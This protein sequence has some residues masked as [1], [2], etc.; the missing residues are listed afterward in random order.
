MGKEKNRIGGIEFARKNHK[1]AKKHSVSIIVLGT[2]EEKLH[3]WFEFF[4]SYLGRTKGTSKTFLSL[5]LRPRLQKTFSRFPFFYLGNL[6]K[7]QIRREKIFPLTCQEQ[8]SKQNTISTY[9]RA[10]V[11]RLFLLTVPT[12]SAYK[13]KV[14]LNPS[15]QNLKLKHGI[16]FN[17]K[18]SI[19]FR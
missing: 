1:K 10:K 8:L 19:L 6:E 7:T 3:V 15:F 16:F 9:K 11:P 17:Q 5:G 2:S 4:P 18:N 13:N 14:S 12:Y